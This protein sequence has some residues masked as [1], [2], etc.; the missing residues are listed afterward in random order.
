MRLLNSSTQ[1]ADLFQIGVYFFFFFF[2]LLFA[3]GEHADAYQR[4]G[5]IKH[6]SPT[7]PPKQKLAFVH[8][9]FV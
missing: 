8:F 6:A 3:G 7:D 4:R 2:F 9:F 5:I 1:R